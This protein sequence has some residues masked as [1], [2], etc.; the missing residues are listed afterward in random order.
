MRRAATAVALALACAPSSLAAQAG[1]AE[2]L[3][4]NRLY[5]QGRFAEA[6]QRYLEGLAQAPGSGVL[7]FNDGNAL[8]RSDDYQRAVEAYQ[9]AVE[10]DD[11]ALASDAWYNLGNALYRQQQ[12][13]PALEAYKQALRLAP[14]DQDAKHNLERVL[15]EMQP[16]Q[17]QRQQDDQNQDQQDQNQ[18]DQ[19]Q[20]QQNQPQQNQQQQNNDQPPPQNQGSQQPRPGQMTPEEAERLLQAVQENPDSVNRQRAPATGVRPRRPW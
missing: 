8:Y 12:L 16:Q 14:S 19:Q 17:Q 10:T 6:H 18:Q 3:D 15:Q 9:R 20:D 7:R 4:G 1:R 13:E 11:P 2:V 5:E